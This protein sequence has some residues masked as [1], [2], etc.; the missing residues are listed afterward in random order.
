[1]VDELLHFLEDLLLHGEGALPVDD[2]HRATGNGVDRLP[3]DPEA[4]AHLLN[5]DEV[6]VKAV[7]HGTDGNIKI[8]LLV[9]EVGAGLANVVLDS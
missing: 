9:V 8:I 2:I 4:L 3:Q 6:A 7:A 5:A 1:M